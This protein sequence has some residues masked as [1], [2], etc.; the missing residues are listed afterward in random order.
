MQAR[1]SPPPPK[2]KWIGQHFLPVTHFSVDAPTCPTQPNQA[3]LSRGEQGRVGQGRAGQSKGGG[4][5][6]PPPIRENRDF[7]TLRFLN[8]HGGFSSSSAS[9]SAG[10]P[11][12]NYKY[13]ARGEARRGAAWRGGAAAREPTPPT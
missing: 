13:R 7:V 12:Q 9:C 4:L 8:E 1:V 3:R 11:E 5:G 2:S 6:S 10:L